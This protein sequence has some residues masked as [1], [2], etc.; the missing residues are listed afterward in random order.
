MSAMS[1]ACPMCGTPAQVSNK[2]VVI[3]PQQSDYVRRSDVKCL[4]VSKKSWTQ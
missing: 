4:A 2:E 1:E 3:E